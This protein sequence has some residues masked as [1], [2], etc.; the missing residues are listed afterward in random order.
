MS[1]VQLISHC[2]QDEKGLFRGRDQAEISHY[3]E[4]Y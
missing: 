3:S 2:F 1:S 4:Y